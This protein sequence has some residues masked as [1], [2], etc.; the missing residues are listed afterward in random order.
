[1]EESAQT[2]LQEG[3]IR[4]MTISILLVLAVGSAAYMIS[5]EPALLR[6]ENL[7]D[8]SVRDIEIKPVVLT[9]AASD[10][11]RYIQ[12]V[13]GVRVEIPLVEDTKI[14]GA[15]AFEPRHGISIPTVLLDDPIGDVDRIFVFTYSLLD[16]WAAGVFLDRSVRLELENDGSYA[17]VTAADG[18]E[19]VLWRSGDDIFLAV[20]Q[21]GASRLISRIPS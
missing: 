12:D 18:R 8:L 9:S 2:P 11:E 15:G 14:S 1:M 20:A 21:Q 4:K 10:V 7:I 6:R 3:A 5:R 13:F 16:E 17:V 19:I